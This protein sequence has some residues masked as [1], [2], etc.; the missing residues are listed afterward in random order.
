M[1]TILT[2]LVV[3]ALVAVLAVDGLAMYSAD[4][5]AAGVAEAA[6]QEAVAHYSTA[7][8]NEAGADHAAEQIVRRANMKLVSVT[9]H[10]AYT[11]WVE[12]TVEATPHVYLVNHLPY[13]KAHL[14]Q[15]ATAV[16]RF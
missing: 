16:V 12:V 7:S 1:R 14:A 6:A 2:L 13:V 11:H 9:F 8:R 10:Q 15:T 4:H 3:G 5:E